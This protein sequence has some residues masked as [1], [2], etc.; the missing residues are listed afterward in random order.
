MSGNTVNSALRARGEDTKEQITGHG[1]WA[2]ARTLIRELPGWDREV[3][4][5]HLAHV[6]DEKLSGNRDRTTYLGQRCRMIQLWADLLDD[7]AAGKAVELANDMHLAS[8]IPPQ[9][10]GGG[11]PTAG[12]SHEERFRVAA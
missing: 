8:A 11:N 7:L 5:R 4:D 12:V 6:S 9:S 10:C 3:I 2:T 1:F